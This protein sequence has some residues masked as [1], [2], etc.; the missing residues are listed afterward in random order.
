MRLSEIESKPR[1]VKLHYFNVT[2]I[3]A[4]ED[5]GLRKDRNGNWFLPQYDRSGQGFDRKASSAMRLFG[6]PYKSISLD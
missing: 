5:L 4:A 1:L 2:D 3:I 6:H